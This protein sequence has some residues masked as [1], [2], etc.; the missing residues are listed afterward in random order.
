ML[1]AL[2][3]VILFGRPLLVAF[4]GP[5]YSEAWLPL[6]LLTGAQLIIGFFGVGWVLLSVGGGERAL[7]RS[8]AISVLG[9]VIVALCL[10]PTL[11][12]IGA[13]IA[14]LIGALIQ[15]VICWVYVRR[16]FGVECTVIGALYYLRV[17]PSRPRS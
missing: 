5:S 17:R 2:L 4:F 7:S 10:V 6:T 3:V 8:Y 16:Q 1:A 9:A 14:A 11:G 15:N 12:T 13:G